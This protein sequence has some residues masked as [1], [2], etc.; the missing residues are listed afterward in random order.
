MS[1]R[2]S[3]AEARETRESIVAGAVAIGSREGL[4]S[5]SF[6][7]VAEAAHLSKSGVSRHFSTKEE[8]QLATLAVGRRRFREE[9]WEPAAHRR[10]GLE[11]LR[12]VME[13]WLGF[14]QVCPFPGGCLVTS[15]ATE[16]DGRSGPVRDA[17]VGELA[18]WRTM[19]EREIE[20]AVRTGELPED[21]DAELL[22]FELGG[23][24]LAT[25]QAVQLHGDGAAAERG[26][27]AVERLLQPSG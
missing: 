1:P 18:L 13:S 8:L 4:E 11:R 3:A 24:A 10:P 9:V 7:R 15:A 23:I 22:A 26:A 19:L 17:V 21:T 2:R 14:L 12:A 16:F 25:N 6:G 5:L 27:R 20:V